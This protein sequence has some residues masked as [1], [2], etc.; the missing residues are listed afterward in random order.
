MTTTTKTLAEMRA[1][2]KDTFGEEA[3]LDYDS[4]HGW[5]IYTGWEEKVDVSAFAGTAAEQAYNEPESS[6]GSTLDRWM[7]KSRT[8][9]SASVG[10][11]AEQYNAETER[12]WMDAWLKVKEAIISG[13]AETFDWEGWTEYRDNVLAIG[14]QEGWDLIDIRNKLNTRR[15]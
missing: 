10:I 6:Y 3:R 1:M 13:K 9:V 11:A 7:A 12:S 14:E 5:V 4:I 15:F 8:T 2:L